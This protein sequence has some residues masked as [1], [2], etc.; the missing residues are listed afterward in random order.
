MQEKDPQ[1]GWKDLL[2]RGNGNTL[3]RFLDFQKKSITSKVTSLW[4]SDWRHSNY[5]LTHYTLLVTGLMYIYMCM[6]VYAFYYFLYYLS[7]IYSHLCVKIDL[8]LAFFCRR[9]LITSWL[10]AIL[11]NFQPIKSIAQHSREI[12]LWSRSDPPNNSRETPLPFRP[13]PLDPWLPPSPA[14][15]LLISFTLSLPAL[16][17]THSLS[18]SRLL[19]FLLR[20]LRRSHLPTHSLSSSLFHKSKRAT[21]RV[22]VRGPSLF[23]SHDSPLLRPLLGPPRRALSQRG[24][25]NSCVNVSSA[26]WFLSRVYR[27]LH[28]PYLA[29]FG[30]RL[31][32]VLSKE[33]NSSSPPTA[34]LLRIWRSILIYRVSLICNIHYVQYTICTINLAKCLSQIVSCINNLYIQY[35]VSRYT[36]KEKKSFFHV[37][38]VIARRLIYRHWRC[39]CRV[40]FSTIITRCMGEKCVIHQ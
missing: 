11:A 12:S 40:A 6:C 36:I 31:K 8:V 16:S 19:L 29:I 26:R 5:W 32:Q 14:T 15:S 20:S 28:L 34:H 27:K 3:Y 9:A 17:F 23:L 2:L 30:N 33:K 13:N 39:R 4:K 37:I 7:S 21:A 25:T 24:I 10:Q 18:F 1:L 22:G 38:P 35:V